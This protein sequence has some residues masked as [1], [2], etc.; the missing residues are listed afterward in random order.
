M[1]VLPLSDATWDDRFSRYD[2][3]WGKPRS[4]ERE[5]EATIAH[6]NDHWKSWLPYEKLLEELNALDGKILKSCSKFR[7]TFANQAEELERIIH[8]RSKLF[9]SVPW[10]QGGMNDD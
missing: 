6:E 1:Y 9:D 5:R 10:N 2:T 4:N 3:K 7:E 8:I